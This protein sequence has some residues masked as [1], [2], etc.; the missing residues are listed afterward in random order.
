[1]DTRENSIQCAIRDFNAGVYKSQRAAARAYGIAPST[2]NDRLNGAA[3]RAIAHQYEQR[4]TPEQEQFLVEWILEEHARGYPPPHARARE[5][6]NRILRINGDLNPVGVDWMGAFLRHNPHV[7]SIVGRP[8]E[9]ARSS[10]ATAEQISAFLQLFESTRTRLNVR[11][12]DTY[13]M[14]ETGTALGVCT[15]TRVLAKAGTK[16][17]YTKSPENREWAT[18]IETISADR[19]KLRCLVIFKGKSLQTT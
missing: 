1:M 4:L 13:N 16:K 3:S 2:L 7:S 10:A 11:A 14:D 15:N 9:A 18:V 8:I 17:A 12:G 5:M 6:A 19:R